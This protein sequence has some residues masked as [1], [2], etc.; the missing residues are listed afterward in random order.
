MG[1]GSDVVIVVLIVVLTV[2]VILTLRQRRAEKHEHDLRSSYI[3]GYYRAAPAEHRDRTQDPVGTRNLTYPEMSA[4][5]PLPPEDTTLH[6]FLALLVPGESTVGDPDTRDRRAVIVQAL[7]QHPLAPEQ[8]DQASFLASVL[9]PHAEGDLPPKVRQI[10]ESL[11]RE[12]GRWLLQL[13]A[14][15]A[16]QL[17]D[18]CWRE[19]RAAM[20]VELVDK[21][22]DRASLTA[23]DGAPVIRLLENAWTGICGLRA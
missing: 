7:S 14:Y 21:Y 15:R 2:I 11:G 23:G 12:G 19:R 1:Q 13:V 16:Q 20:W 10:G 17:A 8:E 4:S 9:Y 18:P 5:G 22:G 3:E 6:E